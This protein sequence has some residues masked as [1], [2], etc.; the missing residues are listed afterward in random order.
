M[1]GSWTTEDMPDLSAKVAIV[2]GA[3][4]GMGLEVARE[5]ARK[6]ARVV[7]ACRSAERGRAAGES[8]R[9]GIPR[10]QVDVLPLDLA[11]LASIGNFVD[12]FRARHHRLDV[13]VN[14]A[15][16][17][18]LPYGT[19]EDGFELHFGINHLGHFALTGRL[20]DRLLATPASRIVTVSSRGHVMGRIDFE[21]L[22]GEDGMRYSA[23]RAYGGSKLANLL[24]TYELQRRLA[25]TATIA[26]AAHPGGAA[27]GLGRRMVDRRIY[28]AILPT[29]ERLSQSAA[30]GARPILRAATDLGV[31]AGQYYG[32]SGRFGM[33]GDP[34]VVRSHRRSHDEAAARRL[35]KVSE[36]LTGVRYL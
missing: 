14:N 13:L 11:S 22:I 28:R 21:N 24:F 30:E 35:W 25:G 6:G 7:L 29:L 1:K 5:L 16:V 8:I 36:E 4:S 10:S 27:T 31:K 33:R 26:V 3:N 23:A 12:A 32:P 2:T 18:L 15:G 34:I 9:S 19:T 17:L 20:I